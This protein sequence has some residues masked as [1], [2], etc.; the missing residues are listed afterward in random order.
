MAKP[1]KR[2]AQ[3]VLADIEA[4]N[5]V[6]V[7]RLADQL[8]RLADVDAIELPSGVTGD[9]IRVSFEGES[10]AKLLVIL[11]AVKSARSQAV[12]GRYRGEVRKKLPTPD[13]H[14]V[15]QCQQW[16]DGRGLSWET[17][18][19]KRG[20][21]LGTT[22]KLMQRHRGRQRGTYQPSKA[23]RKKKRR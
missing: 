5:R 23:L 1:R 13:A 19:K 14:L 12:L 22:A 8:G 17:I 7:Y 18:D 9:Q 4:L 6:E 20:V 15:A 16:H 21:A 11:L 10:S 2:T 3:T